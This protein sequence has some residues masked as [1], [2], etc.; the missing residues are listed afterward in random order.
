MDTHQQLHD[1]RT[2][3]ARRGQV[4]VY[5]F[6]RPL[7]H[8]EPFAAKACYLVYTTPLV[9]VVILHISTGRVEYQNGR[10]VSV[11][12][13]YMESTRSD[14]PNHV[15]WGGKRRFKRVAKIADT[16]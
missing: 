10:P 5:V 9:M 16:A 13:Q 11:P 15:A 14:C 4:A 6:P 2:G 3:V 7:L 12:R 8:L 1:V